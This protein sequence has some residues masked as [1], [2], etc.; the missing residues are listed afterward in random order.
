[1]KNTKYMRFSTYF[2]T[3]YKLVVYLFPPFSYLGQYTS[4]VFQMS[5]LWSRLGCALRLLTS[6][7]SKSRES[8]RRLW[9][10]FG[11]HKTETVGVTPLGIS[12]PHNIGPDLR[13]VELWDSARERERETVIPTTENKIGET[14]EFVK[15]RHYKRDT[16]KQIILW[17][18][19]LFQRYFF[20]SILKLEVHPT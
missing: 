1:M 13:E 2:I 15:C 17:V 10:G 12:T 7:E 8:L 6:C 3:L 14:Y 5:R 9:F 11:V 16:S 20:A 19:A 4:F 18:K